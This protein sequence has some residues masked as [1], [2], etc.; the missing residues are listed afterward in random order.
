MCRFVFSHR[1]AFRIIVFKPVQDEAIA[2]KGF[3]YGHLLWSARP[4]NFDK[5]TS[6]VKEIIRVF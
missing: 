2:K 1:K 4:Y 6:Y 5:L 3:Q